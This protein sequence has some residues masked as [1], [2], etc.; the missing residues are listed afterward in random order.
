[1]IKLS[2]L[3]TIIC[4]VA[5]CLDFG[6]TLIVPLLAFL[7]LF[8]AAFLAPADHSFLHVVVIVPIGVSSMGS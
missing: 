7:G 6:F 2:V 3:I 5:S 4:P 8:P 1:M